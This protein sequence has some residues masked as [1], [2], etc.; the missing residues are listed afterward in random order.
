MKYFLL[1]LAMIC[2]CTVPAQERTIVRGKYLK[3]NL[4]LNNNLSADG[5]G[6]CTDSVHVNGKRV[7]IQPS[8][9]YAIPLDSMGFMEMDS[10]YVEI[11]HKAGC[12]PTVLQ[13]EIINPK[14]TFD[15]VSINVNSDGILQWTTSNEIARLP[16]I[17]EQFRWNKWIKIGEVEGKGG[18]ETN[19]YEFTETMVH[20]GENKF[21]VKQVTSSG[22]RSSPTA[23]YLSIAKAPEI[24]A[25]HVAKGGSLEF[26]KETMYEV[27]DGMGNIAKKGRGKTISCKDLKPG[28]YY[29]NYDNLQTE[30]II[31]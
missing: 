6:F 21:R 3:K 10:I 9:A 30:F 7:F 1:L 17:V 27:Y 13:P 8:A 12:K 23:T 28:S 22:P 20:S 29:L 5:K 4:Y 16:F 25:Y 11:F 18:F 2:C 24:K 19:A 14:S 31:Y 26:D 15:I